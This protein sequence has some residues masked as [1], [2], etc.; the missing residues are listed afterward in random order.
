MRT[1]TRCSFGALL[2]FGALACREE[3]EKPVYEPSL[4]L[5]GLMYDIGDEHR[6]VE[7]QLRVPDSYPDVADGL[8]ALAQMAEHPALIG[9]AED[10]QF[11]RDRERF[12]R[13]RLQ[14]RDGALAAAEGAEAGDVEA[15]TAGF[16]QLDMTCIACHK[17]YSPTY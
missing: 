5:R 14:M 13:F 4:E 16:V 6:D 9:W 15:L 3:E 10:P 1:L 2:L 17:R 8:R 12:E 7:L 11:G